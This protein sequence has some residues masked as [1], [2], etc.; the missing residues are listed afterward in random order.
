MIETLGLIITALTSIGAFSAW[1][2]AQLRREEVLDWGNR[3]IE[4]LQTLQLRCLAQVNGKGS[5]EGVAE[6]AERLSILIEQ[7]RIFFKNAQS[8]QFGAHKE[9]AYRGLRPVILD[10]LVFA[11]MVAD[12]WNSLNDTELRLAADVVC[13][14]KERFV[15]LLQR[16]VGRRRSAD[17]YNVEGG[18]GH[19]LTALLALARASKTPALPPENKSA[20]AR[21]RRLIRF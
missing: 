20:L 6:H 3:C 1:R 2:A 17:R 8:D 13:R 21:A 12:G 5:Y 11:Y 7:G 10:Q 19:N 14:C 9:L 15:S 16:E 18:S 4:S